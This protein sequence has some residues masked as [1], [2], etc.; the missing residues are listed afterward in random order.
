MKQCP[1]TPTS[2]FF[3]LFSLSLSNMVSESTVSNTKFSE[4]FLALTNL[5]RE[6][7]VSYFRKSYLCAKVNSASFSAEL[8][9]LGEELSEFFL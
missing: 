1:Q 2:F 7:S 5:C 4:F 9:E 6:N 8:T 3:S